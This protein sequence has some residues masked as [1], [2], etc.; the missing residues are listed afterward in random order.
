M[1][2]HVTLT[3]SFTSSFFFNFSFFTAH[4]ISGFS[5]LQRAADYYEMCRGTKFQNKHC[6]SG[7]RLP[8]A[9]TASLLR[10][11]YNHSARHLL[12]RNDQV[13]RLEAPSTP[14]QP[15]AG[16]ALPRQ[17][18]AFMKHIKRSEL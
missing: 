4:N 9:N 11:R 16:G 7:R 15:T 17:Q 18:V 13:Q 1:R 12:F 3:L 5:I 14:G 6:T 8:E 10:S 2:E